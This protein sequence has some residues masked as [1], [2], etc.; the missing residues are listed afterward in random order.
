MA[1]INEANGVLGLGAFP[2]GVSRSGA[3]SEADAFGRGVTASGRVG[4]KASGGPVGSEPES[5]SDGM[6]GSGTGRS[7]ARVVRAITLPGRSIKATGVPGLVAR[8]ADSSRG[9]NCHIDF[10]LILWG[11]FPQKGERG[12]NYLRR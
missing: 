10:Q 8:R 7:L 4:R 1:G 3:S 6:A 11:K 9:W 2:G 5:G 12:G